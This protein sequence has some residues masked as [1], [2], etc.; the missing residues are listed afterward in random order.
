MKKLFTTVALAVAAMAQT[1]ATDYT[2]WLYVTIAGTAVP[3]EEKTITVEANSDGTYCLS[4]DNFTITSGGETM[5]VGNITVDSVEA[6]VDGDVTRLSTSQDI[7]IESGDDATVV[8]IGPYLGSVPVSVV[9]EMRGDDMLYAII[10]IEFMSRQINVV[11]GNGGY[12]IGNSDFENFHTATLTALGSTFTSDEPDHWHSFM[13][14]SG[15]EMFLYFAGSEARTYISEEVRPGSDGESS[16]LLRSSSVMGIA[17]GNGTMTTGRIN[18]GSATASDTDSNYSYSDLTSTDTDGNGDPFYAIMY[19]KP[20]SLNVWVRFK[21][22]THSDDA[23]Y[24]TISATVTDESAYQEPYNSDSTYTNIV[25]RAAN[26][27]IEETG[28]DW[29]LISVPFDYDSF[30]SAGAEQG[31]ILVTV[32]TN[33]TAGGGSD[34]DSLLVDDL[35]LIYNYKLSSLS[36][37][38]TAVDGFDKDVTEYSLSYAGEVSADDI[39]AVADGAGATVT[40]ELEDSETGVTATITVT[41][42]DLKNST[43][44]TLD[45][46]GAT[47]GI[48]NVKTTTGNGTSTI[49][50]LSGRQVTTA[51]HGV[52]IVRKADGTTY[53][54]VKK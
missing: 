18:V 51:T 13:S 31:A 17:V 44:Y 30:A 49:Y 3:A 7:T 5:N 8:W 2:D 43:V 20:D 54:V 48:N 6:T 47:N 23:P 41:S 53:K 42:N 11:F 32:S 37:G 22:A 35:E 45:I 4:L 29:T 19:G 46:E 26:N 36:V 24:A 1:M 21:Q 10:D 27:A 34:G 16:V 38:G 25:A 9:A 15:T 40:T 52:Y 14:A 50:D 33:A 28:D 12:Q 39:E